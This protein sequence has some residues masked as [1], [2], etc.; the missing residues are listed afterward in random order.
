MLRMTKKTLLS[1]R[2]KILRFTQNEQIQKKKAAKY[3]VYY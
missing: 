1:L 3:Q 2:F